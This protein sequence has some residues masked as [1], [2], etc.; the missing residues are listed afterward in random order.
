M[1]S[2]TLFQLALLPS[3]VVLVA[4]FSAVYCVAPSLQFSDSLAVETGN[5]VGL[6]DF[7]STEINAGDAQSPS[8]RQFLFSLQNISGEAVV[9]DTVT[10]DC[11]CISVTHER[12]IQPGASSEITVRIKP[13]TQK[14]RYVVNVVAK[15]GRRVQTGKLTVVFDSVESNSVIFDPP[16][17]MIGELIAQRPFNVKRMVR[18]VGP[19]GDSIHPK[20][21]DGP[22]WINVELGQDE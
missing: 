1:K 12:V 10:P 8:E 14:T 22:K 19:N 13:S 9:I 4:G 3:I 20:A 11:T 18:I 5:T 16:T 7:R 2:K 17:V 6:I 15:Q 21:V